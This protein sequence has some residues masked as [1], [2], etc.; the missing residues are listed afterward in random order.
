[1]MCYIYTYKVYNVY[2]NRLGDEKGRGSNEMVF[3]YSQKL[4]EI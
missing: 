1:M 3:I 2:I 4:C